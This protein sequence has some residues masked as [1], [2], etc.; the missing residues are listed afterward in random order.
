[1]TI[2][3]LAVLLIGFSIFS[4]LAIVVTQFRTEKFHD[5]QQSRFFGVIFVI[6]LALLQGYHFEFLYFNSPIAE[7]RLYLLLLLLIAPS[8]FL[9]SFPILKARA[10]DKLFLL[11]HFFPIISIFFLPPD[12]IVLFAF[13]LGGAYL[14]W[15]AYGIYQLR[16]QRQQFAW[17]LSLLGVI[18]LIAILVVLMAIFSPVITPHLFV[19]LH[20]IAVGIGFLL[21]IIVLMYRPMLPETVSVL[22]KE[23]YKVSSLNAVDSDE[24]LALLGQLMTE[25]CLYKD[26]T[27]KLNT[28]AEE[29]SI[30][31]H[32][33]SELLNAR[34]GK[35][36]SRYIREQRVNAAT[37]MLLAEPKASI[38]SVGMMVG[39]SSQSNF[40]DAFRE[41]MGMTPGQYRKI[42]H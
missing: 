27:I 13:S 14:C 20:S 25:Q 2:I 6:A 4:S 23:R 5:N 21:A 40:Y 28:V 12:S 34:L 16:E 39:F 32:Q 1:M 36:F 35:T 24:K 38:L 19:A 17:E 37:N 10:T 30:T 22:A 41:I 3:S 8:F 26:P 15:L 11:V 33:L 7:N 9:F 31:A 42:S 29:L 18:L